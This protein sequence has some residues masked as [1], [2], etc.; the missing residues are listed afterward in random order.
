MKKNEKKSGKDQQS[1]VGLHMVKTGART[2]IIHSILF[3]KQITILVEA[4]NIFHCV[5]LIFSL[6]LTKL[7][8][9]I[10]YSKGFVFNLYAIFEIMYF[11][12]FIHS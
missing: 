6:L 10:L 1:L 11:Y 12:S 5:L 4:I 9:F 7:W 8:D 2:H 3:S